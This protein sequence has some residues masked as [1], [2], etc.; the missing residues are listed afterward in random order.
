[1]DKQKYKTLIF[2]FFL[3]TILFMQKA[4]AHLMNTDLPL[5]QKVIY[6][7][8]GHGGRDPGT[9]YG[10]LLE[11]DLNL[12]IALMLQEELSKK[13]AIVFLT[14]EN[15]T[16]YSTKWDKRKKRGDLS[17]RIQMIEKEKSDL[18]LSIH[19]NWYTDSYWKGAE[20][21]Y[22]NINPNNKRLGES[23]MKYFNE[24][25][26]STRHLT[27]TD[28]YMYNSTKVPGVLIECGFISN[29]SERTLLQQ[30]DYQKKLSKLI[31]QGVIDYLKQPDVKTY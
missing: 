20:V 31:T 13:G 6:V 30:K 10:K 8:P 18:Y 3:I 23:I 15:D 21:L 24:K 22:S 2:I 4:N 17:R 16:D 25:L 26:N 7:D 1:M 19:I 5:F 29:A 12:E 9:S 27:T 11:K 14:R 28:L